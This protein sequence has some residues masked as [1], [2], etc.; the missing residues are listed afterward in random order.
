LGTEVPTGLEG[1]ELDAAN[2]PELSGVPEVS[3]PIDPSGQGLS[4]TP[5]GTS[6]SLPCGQR[7]A[8][9]ELTNSQNSSFEVISDTESEKRPDRQT[10]PASGALG[11]LGG[12]TG[13]DPTRPPLSFD[14]LFALVRSAPMETYDRVAA[15][16]C[17]EFQTVHDQNTLVALLMAMATA[18]VATAREIYQQAVL[19]VGD[20]QPTPAAFL[21]LVRY[22]DDVRHQHVRSD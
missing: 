22:L 14:D 3:D 13:V 9:P 10:A 18:R 7:V 19:R 2:S 16:V 4:P 17:Q 21:E 5:E 11:T 12:E 1:A 15:N 6:E 8:T 20:G